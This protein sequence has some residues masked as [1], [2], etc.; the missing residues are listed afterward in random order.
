[1]K[2]KTKELTGRQLDHVVAT[3]LGYQYV[4]ARTSKQLAAGTSPCMDGMNSYWRDP[5]GHL[6]CGPCYG[7]PYGYSTDWERGGPIIERERISLEQ[8]EQPNKPFQAYAY[9]PGH[10]FDGLHGPT[11]LVAAMRALVRAKLGDEVEIPNE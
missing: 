2:L 10:E 11:P 9:L 8:S 1:M 6:I 3:L 7:L 4:G 5:E